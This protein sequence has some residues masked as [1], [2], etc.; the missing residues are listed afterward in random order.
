[1]V[2]KKAAV[3]SAEVDWAGYFHS[4]QPVCPWSWGAWLQGKISIAKW[5]GQIID[6]GSY[7]A[8]VYTVN[9]NPRRL[10]KLCKQLDAADQTNEW[11]WSH[12]RYQNNS[13]PRPILIQQDRQKLNQIRKQN[14][15]S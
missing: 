14:A 4:I 5:Q 10:K 6:L 12:P 3:A 1:M 11:L 8:R 15:S 9:L 13:A 2:E 7:S